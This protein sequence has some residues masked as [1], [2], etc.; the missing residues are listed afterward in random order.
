MIE[1]TTQQDAAVEVH[2]L[3]DGTMECLVDGTLLWPTPE[4]LCRAVTVQTGRQ[5][6]GR[7]PETACPGGACSGAAAPT[8]LQFTAKQTAKQTD[9][10]R[11][12]Y[13]VGAQALAEAAPVCLVLSFAMLHAHE[14]AAS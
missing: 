14:E 10:Q 12:L 13:S 5:E 7:E 6:L 4:W 8:T 2:V 9:E 1:V 11:H 3:P